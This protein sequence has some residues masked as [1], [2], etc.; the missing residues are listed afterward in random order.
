MSQ[1]KE[2]IKKRIKEIRKKEWKLVKEQKLVNG[3]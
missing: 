2:M 3:S 1:G